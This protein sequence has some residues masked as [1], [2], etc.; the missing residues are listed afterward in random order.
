M[1]RQFT[2][3]ITTLCGQVATALVGERLERDQSQPDERAVFI[4]VL[5]LLDPPFGG[6]VRLLN[7]IVDIQ[8]PRKL[9][10]RA[11]VQHLAQSIS[12]SCKQLSEGIAVTLA[13][14]SAEII[15]G[16][17]CVRHDLERSGLPVGGVLCVR[18]SPIPSFYI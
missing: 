15:D 9:S 6:Q 11:E 5:E 3:C 13:E 4:R 7:Q 1:N 14:P 10:W 8:P 2:A 12:V 17:M 18:Y 16:R